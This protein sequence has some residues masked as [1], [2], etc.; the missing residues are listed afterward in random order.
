MLTVL[1]QDRF[2]ELANAFFSGRYASSLTKEN[3]F[4]TRNAF[5]LH[6]S[7]LTALD[8]GEVIFK[9]VESKVS[10]T[11]ARPSDSKTLT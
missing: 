10:Y 6:A 7:W 2:V 9:Q 8:R 5:T 3:L 11:M 4:S 1:S